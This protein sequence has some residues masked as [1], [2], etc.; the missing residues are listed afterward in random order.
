[1]AAALRSASVPFSLR[2]SLADKKI[3]L[4]RLDSRQEALVG[5]IEHNECDYLRFAAECL[6][7]L[8]VPQFF[9]AE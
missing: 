1:V 8:S 5:R 2:I 6:P 7:N 4:I 9:L 3:L